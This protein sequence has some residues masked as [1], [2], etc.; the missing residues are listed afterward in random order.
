MEHT[1]YI[2]I[3]KKETKNEGFLLPVMCLGEFRLQL[4]LSFIF[5]IADLGLVHTASENLIEFNKN[6]TSEQH[7]ANCS[8]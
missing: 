4:M 8:V 2:L 5:S 1:E 7:F 3:L 6:L